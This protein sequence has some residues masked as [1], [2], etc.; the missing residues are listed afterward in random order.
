MS[1][2]NGLCATQGRLTPEIYTQMVAAANESYALDYYAPRLLDLQNC[3]FVR[4]A[5]QEIA[6][7]YCPPL[8]RYL[9]MVEAGLG[10]ISAG[11][12]LCLILWIFYANRPFVASQCLHLKRF[13]RRHNVTG[14][15]QTV[16]NF[17]SPCPH[18]TVP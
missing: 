18:S 10:L 1:S 8:R 3:N 17:L 15:N 16:S 5:F 12:M 13:G 14:S 4:D 2:T 7:R 6:T 11:V 9:K